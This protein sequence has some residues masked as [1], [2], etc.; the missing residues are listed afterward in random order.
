MEKRRL[1]PGIKGSRISSKPS[2]PNPKKIKGESEEYKYIS[3]PISWSYFEFNGK[4]YHFFGDEHGSVDANCESIN[5]KC[6]DKGSVKATTDCFDLVFLLETLFQD[7]NKIIDLF[8]EL[9]YLSYDQELYIDDKDRRVGYIKNITQR[10]QRCFQRNKDL[11]PYQ[12]VRFHYADIRQ[13]LNVPGGLGTIYNYLMSVWIEVENRFLNLLWID[14]NNIQNPIENKEYIEL[15]DQMKYMDAL[16]QILFDRYPNF[17][18]EIFYDFLTQS[19]SFYIER[20][21]SFYEDHLSSLDSS[22]LREIF[23]EHPKRRIKNGNVHLIRKQ[24]DELRKDKIE[25][26]G[27]NLSDLIEE[28]IWKEYDQLEMNIKNPWNQFHKIFLQTTEA[29]QN[30]S[31]DEGVKKIQ[32]FQMIGDALNQMEVYKEKMEVKKF[33]LVRAEILWMDV[34]TLARMFRTYSSSKDPGGS[35]LVITYTGELHRMN[36][37]K[38]FQDVLGLNPILEEKGMSQ[39]RRCIRTTSY[40]MNH[41]IK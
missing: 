4:R 13:D 20:M 1:G 33:D 27:K 26:N 32:L 37:S 19:S 35:D 5:I 38:F 18:R 22:V 12:N 23:L 16:I 3:G 25:F 10:F 11:C 14:V 6:S 28:F 15:I 21:K 30:T 36:F 8:I 24:L 29:L 39:A 40:R 9:P 2:G 34:Y 7:Q 31:E 41:F 17:H